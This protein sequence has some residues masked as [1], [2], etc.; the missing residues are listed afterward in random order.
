QITNRM[1][2]Q[3][4]V[5]NDVKTVHEAAHQLAFNMG[6][7]KRLVDYPLWLSEGLACSFEMQ[8][9][10][11]RRGPSV[12][13]YGRLSVLKEA[14]K[15]DKLIPLEQ[16]LSRQARDKMDENTLSIFYAEGWAL[17]HYLYRTNR[18]GTEKYLLA[19]NAHPPLRIIEDP[20]RLKLFTDSFTDDLP[21]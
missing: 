14:Q 13:N 12:V 10:N 7:Q 9:R 15:R 8:D 17:F 5:L 3:V 18:T 19:Y 1:D 20:E 6:I 4:G 16:L 2:N 21:T 11:A